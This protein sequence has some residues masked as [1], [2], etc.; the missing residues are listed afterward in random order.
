[1]IVCRFTS[2]AIILFVF[3]MCLFAHSR[4]AIGKMAADRRL[5]RSWHALCL[6][7]SQANRQG[8]YLIEPVV[9]LDGVLSGNGFNG[10]H[11]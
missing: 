4:I 2:Q 7:S 5:S 11:L 3:Q 10:E 6:L 1:M 8:I 9:W